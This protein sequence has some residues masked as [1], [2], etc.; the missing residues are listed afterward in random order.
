M[1]LNSNKTLRCSHEDGE[2]AAHS[3]EWQITRWQRITA[4]T[5]T[6]YG[7][8]MR[9]SKTINCQEILWQNLWSTDKVSTDVVWDRGGSLQ[10][11]KYSDATGNTIMVSGIW[12]NKNYR[13]LGVSPDELL[14][15]SSN[16]LSGIIEIKCLKI[17]VITILLIS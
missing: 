12:I 17:T 1:S 10:P 9:E 8:R 4:S 5:C 15:D 7:K 6:S 2:E 13:H 11:D 14:L 3:D 16:K